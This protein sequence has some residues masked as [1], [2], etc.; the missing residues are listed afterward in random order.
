MSELYIYELYDF[1]FTTNKL[2]VVCFFF[3]TFLSFSHFIN[4]LCHI[5][6]HTV[7]TDISNYN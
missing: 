3:Y 1:L 7:C 4:T 6:Y 2:N 5:G